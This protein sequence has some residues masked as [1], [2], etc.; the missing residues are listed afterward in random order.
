VLFLKQQQFSLQRQ[1][2]SGSC[3][4]AEISLVSLG[5]GKSG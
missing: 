1:D 2:E 4:T 3:P 5:C